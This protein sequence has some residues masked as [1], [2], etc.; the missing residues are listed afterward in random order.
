MQ[1]ERQREY[2]KGGNVFCRRSYACIS[3]A[4]LEMANIPLCRVSNVMKLEVL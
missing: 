1:I 4:I 3:F 2:A